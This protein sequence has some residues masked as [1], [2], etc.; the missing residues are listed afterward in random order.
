MQFIN[1]ILL[2]AAALA[3]LATATNTIIFVNQDTAT[4][5]NIVFTP[6]SGLEAISTLVLEPGKTQSQ[7]FPEAWIGNFYSYDDGSSNVPGMLGEVAWGAWSATTFYDVSSIVNAEDTTGIKVLYPSTDASSSTG[8]SALVEAVT[9]ASGVSGCNTTGGTCTNQYN[10]PD[11][12]ATQATAD[13][14]LVCL[15]GNPTSSVRRSAR[16]ARDYV[17]GKKA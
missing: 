1:T 13:S 12:V 11:D 2:A 15:V 16:F 10:A 17:L 14:T 5:K 3:S 6:N 4:T 9:S 8:V 7:E